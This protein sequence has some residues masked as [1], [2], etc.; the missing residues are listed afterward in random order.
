MHPFPLFY[1]KL[2]LQ[3]IELLEE[4]GVHLT[5][6]QMTDILGVVNKEELLQVEKKIEKSLGH[7]LNSKK[8]DDIIPSQ[9]LQTKG[10]QHVSVEQVLV[11]E[12]EEPIQKKSKSSG[13]EKPMDVVEVEK[14][15][16]LVKTQHPVV[17]QRKENSEMEPIFFRARAN[18][19]SG[20]NP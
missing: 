14:I 2:F 6:K 18:S 12:M 7:F 15:L 9:L 8:Q 16:A 1:V 5:A 10:I 3:V 17:E 4:E 20:L 11:R 19:N 13:R